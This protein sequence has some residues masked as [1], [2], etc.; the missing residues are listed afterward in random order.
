MLNNCDNFNRGNDKKN[1]FKHNTLWI[2]YI[3]P[4]AISNFNRQ[5]KELNK[6]QVQDSTSKIENWIRQHNKHV[7]MIIIMEMEHHRQK[8]LVILIII[9]E[10][11]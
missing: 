10:I 8:I 3:S 6:V 4:V 7:K 1:P 2:T 11:E 9:M 5:K